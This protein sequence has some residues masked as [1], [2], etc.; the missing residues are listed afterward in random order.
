MTYDSPE[1][2]PS[3]GRFE[4]NEAAMVNEDGL[5]L[6]RKPTA[7]NR[8]VVSAFATESDLGEQHDSQFVVAMLNNVRQPYRSSTVKA[9]KSGDRRVAVGP[10]ILAKRW[11]IGYDAAVRTLEATTQRCIRSTLHPTLSRRFRT[12][13]RMLRYRRI[14][15]NMFTDT[16]Q[17]KSESWMR[18]N[19]Y[20]QVFRTKFGWTRVYPMRKKSDAH[21]GL[22]AMFQRDGVPP[23]IIMD[24][25]KEQT[26][27][28]F[29][30]K[31][32]QADCQIKQTEPYSPFSNA[33]E[34][35]IREVKRS[36]GRKMVVSRCPKKLWDHCLEL[37]ALI[38]SHTALNSY[39]LQ[40]QVPETIVS[41]Q[42]ADI[43][44]LVE[45]EWFEWVKFRDN[46]TAFP[47][48]KEILGRWLG[49]ALDIGPAMS[50]KVIKANGQV[51]YTSSHRALT[52]EELQDCQ[53][54]KE[55]DEFMVQLNDKIKGGPVS[56]EE[57][58][59]ID[60]QAVTPEND[61]YEDDSGEVHERVP[62]I[63]DVTPEM[64]DG[65][66]GAQVNLPFQ[67]TQR[68]GTVHRRTRNDEGELQG[69]ANANPILDSRSYQ[70][71]FDDG[72]LAAYSANVIA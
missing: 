69:T 64:Q 38:Q 56:T 29:R 21:E 28:D 32:R 30:S 36:A 9:V 57:L 14:Q 39:E 43:S 41:G 27:G 37:E 51:M 48:P 49:P 65:Y 5:L 19:N 40:G 20:A 34:G 8:T 4:A 55:M 70:V 25:S 3:D 45:Y 10:K 46:P 33:A 1:W 61:L 60:P 63:D 12:N 58:S 44:V 47:E 71:E 42:T 67:G 15:H 23:V 50:A 35:A 66:I 54:I 16:L 52:D 26:L 62:D 17:A 6:E 24:G 31:A 53:E 2:D 7:A 13:D 72:E 22:S 18:K 68:S 11:K 59:S